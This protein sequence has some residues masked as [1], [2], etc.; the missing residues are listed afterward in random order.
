MMRPA[1]AQQTP[2][3]A[4]GRIEMAERAPE[5][6][7][8]AGRDRAPVRKA[9]GAVVVKAAVAQ[10]RVALAVAELVQS[11]SVRDRAPFTPLS[12]VQGKK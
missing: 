11:R 3:V 5:P 4:Q 1:R 2:H 9:G 12:P 6:R 10:V 8:Q 7:A